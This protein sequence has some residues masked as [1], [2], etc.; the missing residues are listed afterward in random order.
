VI[1]IRF[2]FNITLAC[3]AAAYLVAALLI[4]RVEGSPRT[5]GI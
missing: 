3:G 5:R 2:G 4:G 1:A